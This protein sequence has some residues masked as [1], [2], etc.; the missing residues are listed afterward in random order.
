[1]KYDFE[2]I[3]K[4]WQAKWEESKPYAAV[5]DKDK[6][7]FYGLIEFPYPSGAG[8]HV[9][10]PRPFTAMDI[11]TRKKRMQGFSVINPIGYDAFGL[12]TENYAIKNHIHPTKV[13]HDNIANFTRQL[14]M[15]GYGFD[16]DRVVNT[17]DPMYYKW[18]Q[19]IFLQMYKKGLA[20]KA[21]MSVNWCTSC[22]V[23]LANEEVVE[24]VCERCG[25]PVVRK[26]KS[27]WML[28]ITKYADRL[29]DDLDDLDYIERVKTQ[30]KNW[31]G[32]STGCEVT[33][34]T[35]T[36]DDITV[37]TTRADT[38]FGVTYVVISPEHPLLEKWKDTIKNYGEVEAYKE[39]ASRKSDFERGELNKD[40]TGVK[41]EGIEVINPAN[42]EAVP[43]F[44]SDYVLMGYG[45]GIVMGVPGHDQR[46]WEFA[47]KFGLPIIEVV[48]GGD[49]TKEAFVAKDDTA[50]M[51][52]SG[53]LNGMTVKEAIP[54]MK[55]YA[56]DQ[57]WG[58][59]KVNFKLRDWVFSRQRY[60]GEP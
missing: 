6:P 59:E 28:A 46:D 15:L 30:Q 27:Q 53:F 41:L 43:M 32:R 24:G 57:G 12:P 58:K 34:K 54:A 3:E 10:H 9:G 35:S 8:L 25:A 33:F 51:V 13:T 22:K 36:P 37:Y 31:I 56:V 48:S 20:Y 42:G 14:K 55:K 4:K 21:T 29:I 7:K 2:R 44:V 18:T 50:I 11:I 16:W 40:K 52:N 17:S 60:W 49:I 5:M 38:L 39:A 47:T 1:M 45:T 19:W 23:V 26:E